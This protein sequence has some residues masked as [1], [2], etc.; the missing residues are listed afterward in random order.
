LN[1]L[2]HSFNF[3]LAKSFLGFN[4]SK[5]PGILVC[6]C[7]VKLENYIKLALLWKQSTMCQCFQLKIWL[8][9]YH[10]FDLAQFLHVLI[11]YRS[12]SPV[13]NL[14]PSKVCWKILR[15]FMC[16][17]F[18]LARMSSIKKMVIELKKK[19]KHWSA[20]YSIPRQFYQIHIWSV[21]F[22]LFYIK[23]MMTPNIRNLTLK[24]WF[25]VN[26]LSTFGLIL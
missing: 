15:I 7:Q 9:G 5:P 13:K 23:K 16:W 12:K 17:S 24:F 22:R 21:Y 11:L 10:W 1:I 25:I 14:R 3:C 6:G 26:F 2:Y 19:K 8:L 20:L 18:F 4:S